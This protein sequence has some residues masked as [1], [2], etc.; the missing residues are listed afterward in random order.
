MP[1]ALHPDPYRKPWAWGRNV[2]CAISYSISPCFPPSPSPALQ[3][4]HPPSLSPTR[5]PSLLALPIF[6]CLL[7]LFPC[8]PSP[9]CWYTRACRSPSVRAHDNALCRRHP[10]LGDAHPR[11]C[12]FGDAVNTASRMELHGPPGEAHLSERARDALLEQVP[13][14]KDLCLV[15]RCVSAAI[16]HPCYPFAHPAI[17][18]LA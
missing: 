16:K 7:P 12:L 15:H 6:L 11:Y 8:V 4:T 2:P 1:D 17:A 9:V 10:V 14:P 3:P 5:P 18:L 13:L